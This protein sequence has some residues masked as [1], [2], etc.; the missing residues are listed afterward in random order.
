MQIKTNFFFICGSFPV[1]HD[2]ES[3]LE[4]AKHNIDLIQIPKGATDECQTL[5]RRIFGYI[6]QQARAHTHREI[7]NDFLKTLKSHSPIERRT[8]TKKD[9]CGDLIGIW[10]NVSKPQIDKAWSLAVNGQE[11]G[12]NADV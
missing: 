11:K 12:E 10:D 8:K 5:D 3:K 6:K 9:S 2:E 1:H 7:A 4:A